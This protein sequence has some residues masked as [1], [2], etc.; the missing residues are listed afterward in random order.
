MESRLESVPV[1]AVTACITDIAD[2]FI[3]KGPMSNKKV[4]KLCYY[5]E[6]WSE[7]LLNKKIAPDADFE[8]WVHGPGNRKLWERFRDFGWREFV[9]AD[10]D[11]VRENLD[12]VLTDDQKYVLE[13]VWITYKD[14]SADELEMLTH[15]E[16]PWL[17]KRTG[18]DRFETGRRRISRAAMKR[19]YR[20]K[21]IR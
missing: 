1:P 12:T 17:E 11:G 10:P 7:A 19:Y 4:Q 5:A 16:D 15:Q 18:L 2:W 3:L 13:S 8:A 21:M 9:L 20:S 6:A 14:F